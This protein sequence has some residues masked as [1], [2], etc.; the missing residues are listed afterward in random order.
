[1][2]ATVA[3]GQF[4]AARGDWSFAAGWNAKANHQGSFVWADRSR[5]GETDT[6]ATSGGHQ[7]LVRSAGGVTFYSNSSESVGVVL[8]PGAGAW[9]T[10]SDRTQKTAVEMVDPQAVLRRLAEIEIATWRYKDEAPGIRHMGPMAQDFYAAF[11]LGADERHIVTVD[12]DG[13]ALAAI[14]GLYAVNQALQEQSRRH[15]A[16]IAALEAELTTLRV[17][18]AATE[19]RLAALEATLGSRAPASQ[20]GTASGVNR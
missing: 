11:G 20:A 10:A 14:Q 4:N 13:V 9:S 12:A 15:Q 5:T 3:G 6:L 16:K 7:F 1:M 2:V 8:N 19:A 18:A 17:G